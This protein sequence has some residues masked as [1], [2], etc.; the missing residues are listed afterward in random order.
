MLACWLGLA[1][2]SACDAAEVPAVAVAPVEVGGSPPAQTVTAAPI[3]GVV[4]AIGDLHGDL[5][6]TTKVLQLAGVTDTEGHWSGQVQV[7]VQTGDT[8]DRGPQSKS[9]LELLRR[10]SEEAAAAGGQVV[11]LLGNH[12]AMN[13]QGDWRYVHPGDV[14]E[15]GGVEARAAAFSATGDLGA[16][17]RK[18]D[19]VALVGDTVFVHGGLSPAWAVKGLPAVNNAVR[20]ALDQPQGASVLGPEGPLWLRDYLQAPESIMCPQLA[21]ALAPL[22]ARRMVV[23]HTTQRDGRVAV[24]CNGALLGID[25][26]ISA[27]YGA[28]LAAVR[29]SNGDAVAVYADGTTDL[30]DPSQP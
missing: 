1:V 22:G 5:A 14:T 10:L 2:V 15:F 12:E 21:E 20:S 17:L 6:A 30:I 23:G 28:H 27:H 26:G 24:R 4:V 7:L 25:T 29:I 19:A 11:A 8:T 18:R 16:W 13:I 3:A 9:V